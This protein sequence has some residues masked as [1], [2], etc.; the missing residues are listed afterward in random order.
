MGRAGL[1]GDEIGSALIGSRLVRDIMRLSF[2]MERVYAPYAKWFGTAFKQLKCAAVLWPILLG[3]LRAETW[4]IRERHL[5]EAYEHIAVLHNALQLTEPL[6]EQAVSFHGRPFQVISLHRFT[7]ALLDQIRDPV[8]KGIAQR[9]PI[10]SID[11][12]SDSTDLVS[13]PSWR[14]TLR[15]LYQRALGS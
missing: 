11:Q 7:E 4:Q 10:G 3:A 13:D 14:P 2:L 8:V 15:Q 6:P 5:V 12:F 1:V 9:S